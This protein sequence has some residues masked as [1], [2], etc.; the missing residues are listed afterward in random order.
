[1]TQ[2]DSSAKIKALLLVEEGN[3]MLFH[4]LG[5]DAQSRCQHYHSQLDIASLKCSYCERYYACY[6]C[7]D[8]LESHT[9]KATLSSEPYPVLCGVCLSYLTLK[10]YKNGTCPVCQSAFNPACYLHDAIYFKKESF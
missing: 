4:G 10:D 2:N 5:L 1:M 7:H 8:A 3:D 9:F 6:R